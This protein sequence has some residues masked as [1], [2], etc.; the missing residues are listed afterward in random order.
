[1]MRNDG[2]ESS[3]GRGKQRTILKIKSHVGQ[4]AGFTM[5]ELLVVVGIIAVLIAI[6]IP[7]VGAAKRTTR[8]AICAS[9]LRQLG[10]HTNNFLIDNRGKMFNYVWYNNVGDMWINQLVPYGNLDRERFCPEANSAP[11][12]SSSLSSS[13]AFLPGAGNHDAWVSDGPTTT[14]F[15]EGLLLPSDIAYWATQVTAKLK[16]AVP[17]GSYGINGWCYATTSGIPGRDTNQA[18]HWPFPATGNVAKIPL[19]ADEPWVDSWPYSS[20]P[21]PADPGKFTNDAGMGR[22][23]I[24]RHGQA[25]NIV[26]VD[27]HVEKVPL[28]NLWTLQWSPN[29][30]GNTWPANPPYVPPS[31]S[32]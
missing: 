27:D 23:C 22:F 2:L 15:S 8:T 16:G 32:N 26:F 19:Y 28:P 13:A 14:P 6:I 9:N 25:V 17:V 1:M 5:L 18:M 11:Y 4:R 29:T 20:D 30:G 3:I 10:L 31:S 21:A 7:A 24:A 12:N